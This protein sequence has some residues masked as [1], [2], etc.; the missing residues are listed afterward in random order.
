MD[1]L[2]KFVNKSCELEKVDEVVGELSEFVSSL[3][4]L[5][6][7][8]EISAPYP[9]CLLFQSMGLEHVYLILKTNLENKTRECLEAETKETNPVEI[10]TVSADSGPKVTE[11]IIIDEVM[12]ESIIRDSGP[13]PGIDTDNALPELQKR[14]NDTELQNVTDE[15]ETVELVESE[16]SELLKVE[17]KE[18][19]AKPKPTSE[20]KVLKPTLKEKIP[21]ESSMVSE[22]QEIDLEKTDPDLRSLCGLD[23]K[24]SY[25]PYQLN[26]LSKEAQNL[27]TKPLGKLIRKLNSLIE[28]LMHDAVC[29]VL[30]SIARTTGGMRLVNAIIPMLANDG[31]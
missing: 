21:T 6:D 23:K 22:P 27:G 11:E 28:N 2:D 4:Q 3:M 20:T 31:D 13:E 10:D 8:L 24:D 12:K 14:L 7:G 17:V 18:T 9:G 19:E 5:M 30:K 15:V 1:E 29:N 25:K 16:M 26:G